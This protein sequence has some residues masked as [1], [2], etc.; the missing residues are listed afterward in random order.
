MVEFLKF[1]L[2]IEIYEELCFCSSLFTKKYI[3]EEFEVFLLV[4]KVGLKNKKW[5]IGWFVEYY[6]NKINKVIL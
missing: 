4:K 5:D 2:N 1:I 6:C 3:Y